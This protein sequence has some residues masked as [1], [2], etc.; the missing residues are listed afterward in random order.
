[1]TGISSSC[2]KGFIHPL[3]SLGVSELPLTHRWARSCNLWT[4][5]EETLCGNKTPLFI[6]I[7]TI[8]KF[9]SWIS[10][11]REGNAEPYEIQREQFPG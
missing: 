1:M 9:T 5:V 10:C 3:L 4:V 6:K 8:Q 2:A 7:S 11:K